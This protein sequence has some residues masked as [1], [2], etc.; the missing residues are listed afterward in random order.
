[1]WWWTKRVGLSQRVAGHIDEAD[2]FHIAGWVT[3]EGGETVVSVEVDGK[4]V[5]RFKPSI[6]R[7]DL[8]LAVGPG[9]ALGFDH[10]YE[11]PLADRATVTVRAQVAHQVGNSVVVK[12]EPEEDYQN[13]GDG[14][15]TELPPPNLIFTVVGHRRR[16]EYAVNRV[17]PV[18]DILSRL[19]EVSVG[20]S[21]LET[22]LDFG[23]G[24][25]RIL[26]GWENL[27]GPQTKLLGCDINPKLIEFTQRA[28][29]F[30]KTFVSDYSPP[31]AI[32]SESVDLVYAASVFTH[33]DEKAAQDWANE[34]HRILRSGGLALVSFHGP[35][36][37]SELGKIS[38][39]G[40]KELRKRGFYMYTHNA[41]N[42]P[43]PGANDHAT[44]IKPDYFEKLFRSFNL[45]SIKTS[46][47]FMSRHDVALLRKK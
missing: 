5:A 13:I 34:F 29:P 26:A 12:A 23:C 21:D 36:Y 2:C 16:R 35:A 15:T 8:D 9:K 38:K 39:Q 28:I 6:S 14:L 41:A 4:E 47:G 44:F 1:M 40:L 30:A 24:A 32:D 17:P 11:E 42:K 27:K 33:L 25:G 46:K 19:S 10:V 18:R 43:T 37:E 7:A 3:L 20:P 45:I 31:L 22:I